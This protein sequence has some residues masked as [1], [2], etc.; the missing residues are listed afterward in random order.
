MP[1]SDELVA[2]QS[3]KLLQEIQKLDIETKLLN[4]RWFCQPQYLATLLP[5]LAVVATGWITYSNSEFKRE[6]RESREAVAKLKP[7]V[8]NLRQQ[9]TAL[10]SEKVSL[11]SQRDRLSKDV[12]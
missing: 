11:T 8:D 12:N 3:K 10:Q 7:E 9:I 6:A 1:D 4:R 2:L 5:I